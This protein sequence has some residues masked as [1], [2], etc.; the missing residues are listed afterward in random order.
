MGIAEDHRKGRLLHAVTRL[1]TL[2][3]VTEYNVYVIYTGDRDSWKW[4]WINPHGSHWS[5][6]FGYINVILINRGKDNNDGN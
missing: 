5:H 6:C 4:I 2:V 3:E 1:G